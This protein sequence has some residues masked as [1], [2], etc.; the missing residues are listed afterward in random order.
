VTW[1]VRQD[2]QTYLGVEV[3][4]QCGGEAPQA[5]FVGVFLPANAPR[6]RTAHRCWP[7]ANIECCACE[8]ICDPEPRLGECVCPP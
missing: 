1:A 4:T 7:D 2:G 5:G 3:G 8:V 6:A